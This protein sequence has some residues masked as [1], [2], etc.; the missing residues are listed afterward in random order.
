MTVARPCRTCGRAF[1]PKGKDRY[2]SKEC[3]CG[4]DAGYNAGCS[5]ERCLRAHARNHKKLRCIP[6]PHVDAT[7]ARRRIQALARL[8][9]STAELSRRLGKHRS[10][11]LKVLR[12]KQLE[13]TTVLTVMRLYDELSMTWCTSPTAGRTA[14]AAR[15]RGWHPPLAWDDSTIDDPSARPAAYVTGRGIDPVVIDRVMTGEWR[16]PTTREERAEVIRRWREEDRG[17]LQELARRTGWKPER[18]Y[19]VTPAADHEK[20][21]A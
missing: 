11:L 8:G 20:E 7:G 17:S 2:C 9:W 4:T 21:V 3:R 6:N 1:P 15:R 5:C 19:D 14:A 16:L 18:Y 10:Y 12:N 13:P